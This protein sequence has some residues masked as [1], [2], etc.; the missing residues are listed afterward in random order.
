MAG[1]DERKLL[2]MSK[3]D[4]ILLAHGGGGEL[5]HRLLKE[6]ILPKLSN[7]TLDPLLDSAILENP[8]G[9]ICMTTDSYVV[10][11]LQFPGGDI[12]KLAVCGTVND[13]SVMGAEPLGLSLGMIIEEGTTLS[14]LSAIVDSIAAASREAGVPIVTGDTK[15]VERRGGDGLMINTAGVGLLRDGA[16]LGPDKLAAGDALIVNGPIAEHGLAVMS[17]REDLAFKTNI[18]SDVAPLNGLIKDILASGARI[19]FIRDMTRAGL[20]GVLADICDTAG[21]SV[22]VN[23]NDIPITRACRHIAEMLGLDPLTVANEGKILIA[24]AAE[25]TDKVIAACHNHKYGKD[26]AVIGTLTDAK[27]P[28]AELLTRNGGRRIVQRPY[29]EE[30]PRIC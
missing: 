16:E 11:P 8:G 2:G 1:R 14:M 19:K 5:T 3:D 25:D 9:R 22:E 7:P 15:V 26:A 29:G 4:T 18:E 30:L 21:F 6:T 28:L 20:A 13:L 23:E 24:V 10:Q 27:P 17:A 12:G